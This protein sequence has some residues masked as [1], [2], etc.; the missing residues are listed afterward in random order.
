[1]VKSCWETV[2]PYLKYGLVRSPT[3]TRL[4]RLT[5]LNTTPEPVHARSC[6]RFIVICKVFPIFSKHCTI[7]YQKVVN[8]TISPKKKCYSLWQQVLL[9]G[10][11]E[12]I[13]VLK[14]IKTYL[15]EYSATDPL[16]LC[17]PFL[18]VWLST[19]CSCR[20]NLTKF[21]ARFK[22]SNDKHEFR[23]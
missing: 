16:S 1:M 20:L 10:A 21:I 3:M 8:D 14:I 17:R 11:S 2:S 4:T 12:Y 9:V 6:T 19:S 15:W 7:H 22:V 5:V 23:M 18:H 13:G